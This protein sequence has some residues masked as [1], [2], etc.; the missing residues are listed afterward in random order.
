MHVVACGVP[1][2]HI[3]CVDETKLGL[4]GKAVVC[5]G[6]TTIVTNLVTSFSPRTLPVDFFAGHF[7]TKS[8]RLCC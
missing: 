3:L 6:A 8:Q 7:R 1:A 2:D 5:P 4:I